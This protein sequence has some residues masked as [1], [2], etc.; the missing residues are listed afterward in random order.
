M[1]VKP[2]ASGVDVRERDRLWLWGWMAAILVL[3]TIPYV[4]ATLAAPEGKVFLGA[5]LNTDD[6]AQFL[7]AMRQGEQGRWLYRNP[8]TPEDTRPVVMYPL[9]VVWGKLTGWLGFDR[10]IAYHLLRLIGTVLLL[11]VVAT[12]ARALLSG[13]V[14]P[15]LWR[16][17]FLLAAFSSGLGWLAAFLPRQIG[18]GLMADLA[19][20]EMS[21]FQSYFVVPHFAW[22]L[23]LEL[24]TIL[25]FLR[26]VTWHA[27]R[28]RFWRWSLAGGLACL[29]TGLVY[30]FAV[31]VVY[32][33]L[34]A[35]ALLAL[36][37]RRPWAR[38]SLWS[39]AII[40]G[41]AAP[42]VVY[43]VGVF[44]ID[45]LW[46]STHVVGNTTG[47]P[48]ILS[49][50][51]GYG[52]VLVLAI[53]GAVWILGEQRWRSLGLGYLLVWGVLHGVL[54]YAPVTF[55][56]RFAAGWHV[57]LS[58]LAAPGVAWLAGR[59]PAA[60]AQRVQN[61]MVILTIPSTLLIL[62]AGPYM[63]VTQGT[64]PFYLHRSELRAVDWLAG[65]TEE[66]DVVLASY[67]MGNTIPTRASCRVFVGHQFESYRLDE[68]LAL[69]ETFFDADTPDG[70]RKAILRDYGVT[71]LYYGRIE[72]AMG[73]FDPSRAT[74]V[75]RAYDVDGVAIYAVRL[76]A[77]LVRAGSQRSQV[78]EVE[79]AQV[80]SLVA[81]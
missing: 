79:G 62:L 65:R 55:Q 38:A 31:V 34:G 36:A 61:V 28:D 30:P 66:Q 80:L 68:K 41:L 3:T 70:E 24:L 35:A 5:L 32:A 40:A 29:G 78:V 4:F 1:A 74:Y 13:A 73:G 9:Y 19:L 76:D 72:R 12:L 81:E 15:R 46:H 10:V 39:T 60:Q 48:S 7:A 54:P 8:F 71:W 11:L 14:H 26:A 23:M 51:F 47:S 27:E 37:T 44:W 53:G 25:C 16:T 6:T 21:T 56:G 45:P 57:A 52:L 33:V 22:G 18:T 63:A 50:A 43:Y 20:I 58:V 69:V 42:L 59:V 17:A 2:G 75:E 77:S 49:M 67:A 64:Y